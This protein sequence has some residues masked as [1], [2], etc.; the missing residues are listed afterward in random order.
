MWRLLG[1]QQAPYARCISPTG[2]TGCGRVD[3]ASPFCVV[4]QKRFF[5]ECRSR[6]ADGLGVSHRTIPTHQHKWSPLIRVRA[7]F[8]NLEHCLF[9]GCGFC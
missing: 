4:W 9:Q 7:S 6:C 3:A 1:P 5:D 8:S 2:H